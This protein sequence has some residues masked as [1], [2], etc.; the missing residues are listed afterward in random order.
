LAAAVSDRLLCLNSVLGLVDLCVVEAGA[1]EAAP[2]RWAPCSCGDE[3]RHRRSVLR[4][5]W[6]SSLPGAESAMT[7]HCRVS[8]IVT[9]KLHY[10]VPT[11]PDPGLRQSPRVGSG[12]ARVVELSCYLTTATIAVVSVL[13]LAGVSRTDLADLRACFPAI[14]RF[15]DGFRR[16]RRE[17]WSSR[18]P[19]AGPRVM[20]YCETGDTLSVLAAAQ[21]LVAVERQSVDAVER[22]LADAGCASPLIEPF[23]DLLRSIHD[24]RRPD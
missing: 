8:G 11:G 2:D 12:R 14:N 4:L 20:I 6:V 7:H 21:Y 3:R 10:T 23:A 13:R 18:S 17:A 24:Q 19:A 1:A 22:C 9:A 5:A 15:V 16:R